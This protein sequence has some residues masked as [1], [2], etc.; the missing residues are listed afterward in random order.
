MTYKTGTVGEFMTWTK[1]VIG[2][3]DDDKTPKLW[4]DNDVT[5]ERRLGTTTS[6]E[7]MVKLLSEDNLALLRLIVARKPNSVR[8][9]A[10]LA[11]RKE[12]NLS[13]TLRKLRDAGIVEFEEG[14][15]RARAPRVTARRVTLELDLVGP[16]SLVYVERSEVS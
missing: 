2:K 11:H 16:G 15:G 1:R 7:A 3:T 9:L 14:I 5:A 13:R 10:T 6:P 8:E 12:S 4:F